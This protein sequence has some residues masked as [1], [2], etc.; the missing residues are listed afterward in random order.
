MVGT[1]DNGV[2]ELIDVSLKPQQWSAYGAICAQKSM[3]RHLPGKAALEVKDQRYTTKPAQRVT[4]KC[5]LVEMGM[6]DV[7]PL[8]QCAARRGGEQQG[9]EG[10]FVEGGTY[11]VASAPRNGGRPHDSEPGDILTG[12]V[13]ADGDG[14]AQCLEG[15]RLQE[16]ANVTSVVSEEGCGSQDQDLKLSINS[17]FLLRGSRRIAASCC[18]ASLA[19]QC[20]RL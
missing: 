14:V 2:W 12:L 11:L 9:I 10:Q 3:V 17:S 13:G 1:D 4:D 7:R 5:P 18:L 6:Y 15:Q 20:S 19:V 8:P 16:D